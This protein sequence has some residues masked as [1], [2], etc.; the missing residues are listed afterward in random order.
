MQPFCAQGKTIIISS[1]LP[2]EPPSP[3]AFVST[4]DYR[5]RHQNVN[6]VRPVALSWARSLDT[7]P[8]P[9]LL[10]FQVYCSHYLT[11]NDPLLARPSPAPRKPPIVSPTA[12]PRPL[13][14][15][16]SALRIGC[17]RL[18][19][20]P[21]ES[22]RDAAVPP[23]LCVRCQTV[24]TLSSLIGSFNLLLVRLADTVPTC[25]TCSTRSGFLR[26]LLLLIS[27]R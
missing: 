3:D 1:S 11:S 18:L 5:H 19:L 14:P 24:G 21:F 23:Q 4:I 13:E 16:A 10:L 26:N 2:I 7:V 6:R 27:K 8:L 17:A 20:L 12:V 9:T 25:L 22:F 15:W